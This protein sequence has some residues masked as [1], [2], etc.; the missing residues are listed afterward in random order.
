MGAAFAVASASAASIEPAMHSAVASL[1]QTCCARPAAS[2][3]NSVA[4]TYV[5]SS[6][7]KWRRASAALLFTV[8]AS[9]AALRRHGRAGLAVCQWRRRN[10]S[11]S[12]GIGHSLGGTR[13]FGGASRG[14][15]VAVSAIGDDVLCVEPL[16]S[17]PSDG[18]EAVAVWLHGLGDTGQGWSSTA[19]ALQRMGLPMLRFLFPT[20]PIRDTMTGSRGPCPSWYDVASLDPD[21]ISR[22]EGSPPGLVE[23]A[24]SVLDLV[25]P[26]VRRGV[27]PSRIFF[28]GYSQGGGVALAAA[29]RAPRP[30]GGAL[31]L[32]SWVAEPVVPAEHAVAAHVF[33]GAEDPVVPLAAAKRGCDIL[34]AAGLKTSFHAYR[35][36]AHSVCDE[37]VGDIARTLY[38]ALL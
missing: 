33:H 9:R 29:L 27:P 38:E 19:P 22:E 18:G 10:R 12:R 21:V 32:S 17:S 6:L 5:A 4:A 13:G 35:G 14:S 30:V 25:E 37:E 3:V 2:A 15:A 26:Y 8:C 1:R 7:G 31:L 36:M 23:S 28:I 20:A 11:V 16:S 24:Q 34:Q